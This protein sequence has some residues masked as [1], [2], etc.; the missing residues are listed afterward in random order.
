MKARFTT[1]LELTPSGIHPMLYHFGPV[2]NPRV[3]RFGWMRYFYL[4]ELPQR[5][6]KL[7]IGPFRS[8]RGASRAWETVR[9]A[10]TDWHQQ[11]VKIDEALGH[12][13]IFSKVPFNVADETEHYAEDIFERGRA[14]SRP[15][16][17]RSQSTLVRDRVAR[18]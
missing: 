11:Q 5:R 18:P 12:D 2:R 4:A 16:D 15:F 6:I 1:Y 9:D 17:A 7:L 3:I 14:I 8:R 10:Y 13:A